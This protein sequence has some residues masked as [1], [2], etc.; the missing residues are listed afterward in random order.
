MSI[1][2][3]IR[4]LIKV[5]LENMHEK[6]KMILVLSCFV[7]FITTYMLIL[8]AF[9]LDIEEAAEQGG[10]DVPGVVQSAEADTAK[11]E[12][13]AKEDAASEAKEEMGALHFT[14]KPLRYRAP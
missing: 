5:L 10:I 13:G 9:T 8:P 3:R 7:V 6:R 1:Q 12:S 14:S 2:A 4:E 11:T